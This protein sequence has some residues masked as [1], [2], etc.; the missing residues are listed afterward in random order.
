MKSPAPYPA[1]PGFA[2]QSTFTNPRGK[3][4]YIIT[5]DSLNP[6]DPNGVVALL[7]HEVVHIWQQVKEHIGERQPG[8]EQEAYFVQFVLG[9]LLDV[10]TM[11]HGPL[12]LRVPDP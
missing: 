6:N 8:E 4:V 12:T 3:P 11:A 1:K 10:Y 9:Y 7:A 5:T 2:Q